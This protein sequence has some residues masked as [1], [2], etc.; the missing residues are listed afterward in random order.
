MRVG[1]LAVMAAAALATAGPG[2]AAAPEKAV[3]AGGCF[4]CMEEAFEKVEGVS[5]V[6]LR[7]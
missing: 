7:L 5:A 1:I 4:W 6:D 3:F 2:S